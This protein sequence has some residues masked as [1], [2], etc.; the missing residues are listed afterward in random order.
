MARGS[1]LFDVDIQEIYLGADFC[2]CV[3]ALA[4]TACQYSHACAADHCDKPNSKFRIRSLRS[5]IAI[6]RRRDRDQDIRNHMQLQIA[7]AHANR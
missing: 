6:A 5:R 3:S 7:I 2:P 4:V 1:A